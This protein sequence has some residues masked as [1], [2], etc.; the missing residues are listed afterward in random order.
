MRLEEILTVSMLSKHLANANLPNL[1]E[2]YIERLLSYFTNLIN[3]NLDQDAK[4]AEKKRANSKP[5]EKGMCET[6]TEMK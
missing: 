3:W 6:V 4:E 2:K 5:A 1:F